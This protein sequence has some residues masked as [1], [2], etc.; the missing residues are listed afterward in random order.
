MQQLA[1]VLQEHYGLKLETAGRI[2][3]GI[4][5]ESFAIGT[6]RGQL[7]AKRF[8]RKDRPLESMLRGL[9]LSQLLQAQG[10]PAPRLLR[11]HS[12]ALLAE[13]DGERYQVN[14]WVDG[15][16]YHPGE[17]PDASA[18]P[19]GGLL[20]RL[21]R[22]LAAL[23]GAPRG[24][25][26]GSQGAGSRAAEPQAPAFPT[27]A[28]AAARCRELALKYA[29]HSE[30]FAQAAAG[31]LLEQGALLE[32]LPD[33]YHEGLPA[34]TEC[35]ACFHSYWVEQLL[36]Q[37]DG[38]VAALV[39]WTDGAGKPG[40][41]VDDLFLG[42]HLSALT[43]AQTAAY[44]AAYQAEHPLPRHEWQALAAALCYGTLASTNFLGAWFGR[45]YRRM[46]DWEKTALLWHGQ[47]PERFRQRTVWERLIL[48]AAGV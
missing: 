18:G 45:P 34:P 41:W 47:I 4:W 8:R 44:V 7:Y 13:A 5:E 35:G 6:N 27:P 14:E 40:H 12:G 19:M 15:Q 9:E 25:G 48:Q 26:A 37:P 20:G 43:P 16:T 24:G 17:L 36:F 38:Q 39:D 32:T 22:M 31:I 29:G 1:R 11:T 46:A 3:F 42:I 10:F 30:P 23:D 2:D 33:T 21:H 28:A